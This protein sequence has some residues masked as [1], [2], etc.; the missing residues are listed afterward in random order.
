MVTGAAQMFI[1]MLAPSVDLRQLL[2][3]HEVSKG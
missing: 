2:G 1:D 3:R